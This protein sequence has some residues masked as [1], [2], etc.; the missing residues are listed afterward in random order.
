MRVGLDHRN[1]SISQP[2]KDKRQAHRV[3]GSPPDGLGDLGRN[4]L[5]K[6]GGFHQPPIVHGSRQIACPDQRRGNEGARES[7]SLRA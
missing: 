6:A 7:Q 2:D 4:H 3:K 1:S 5:I